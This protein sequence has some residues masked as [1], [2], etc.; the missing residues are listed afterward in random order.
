MPHLRTHDSMYHLR[1]LPLGLARQR[2]SSS[3]TR[4]ACKCDIDT[5]CALSSSPHDVKADGRIRDAH[6]QHRT[7]R[8]KG[9]GTRRNSARAEAPA[10][11]T[12]LALSTQLRG[13]VNQR[14]CFKLDGGRHAASAGMCDGVVQYIGENFVT[15][16]LDWRDCGLGRVAQSTVCRMQLNS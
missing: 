9:G 12:S 10:F 6:L 15:A 13:C 3:L 2:V 1:S 7:V 5:S 16:C 4:R 11:A 8:V 14:H